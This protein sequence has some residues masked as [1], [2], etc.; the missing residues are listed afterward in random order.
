[1]IE[2][3]YIM[4]CTTYYGKKTYNFYGMLI[5]VESERGLEVIKE[6]N[7]LTSDKAKILRLISLCNK[8]KVSEHCVNEIV[9]DFIFSENGEDWN[10]EKI[11]ENSKKCINIIC[12]LYI[13]LFLWYNVLKITK[14]K[15]L[16]LIKFAG[17]IVYFES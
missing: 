6:Y 2:Q 14:P 7:T 15:V 9:E 16:K 12:A 8:M 10:D 11:A 4:S 13:A 1:M 5:V 17:S 3:K